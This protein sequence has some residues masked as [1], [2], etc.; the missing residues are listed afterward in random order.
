MDSDDQFVD[1]TPV[2]CLFDIYS[3]AQSRR[4]DFSTCPSDT[5]V[6]SVVVPESNEAA[7]YMSDG[8]QAYHQQYS[9]YSFN[10]NRANSSASA[11][12]TRS[13][14]D[15]SLSE[16][17]ENIASSE[18]SS[19][20]Y[21]WYKGPAYTSN[22][23]DQ[24]TTEQWEPVVFG[25]DATESSTSSP[26]G[27]SDYQ[28]PLSVE[29][30]SAESMESLAVLYK[31]LTN[32]HSRATVAERPALHKRLYTEFTREERKRLVRTLNQIEMFPEGSLEYMR[33]C[34]HCPETEFSVNHVR[35][36]LRRVLFSLC[37][38]TCRKGVR[39]TLVLVS[40]CQTQGC[41]NPEHYCQVSKRVADEMSR[42]TA[43][44]VGAEEPMDLK[45]M[46]VERHALT[47]QIF[48]A[49]ARHQ[50]VANY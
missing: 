38:N 44:V 4:G 26:V 6:A 10:A 25:D 39:S 21:S 28:T 47:E 5:R 22:G 1:E 15:A 27:L 17:Y 35:L 2:E 32:M 29:S 37:L 43:A 20:S 9:F 19:S 45:T 18:Y 30:Q 34:R 23:T 48:N 24:D 40:R 14:V 13:S 11:S 50:M 46:P 42:P 3:P 33:G 49:V 8:G 12:S 16:V 31:V 41:V 7:Q 36:P